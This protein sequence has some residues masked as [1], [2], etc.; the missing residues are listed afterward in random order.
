MK[1][2]KVL[3]SLSKSEA[4]SIIRVTKI[5]NCGNSKTSRIQSP[6]SAPPRSYSVVGETETVAELL[7]MNDVQ[8]QFFSCS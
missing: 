3:I 1:S 2:I 6:E 8:F 5:R 4:R 7:E